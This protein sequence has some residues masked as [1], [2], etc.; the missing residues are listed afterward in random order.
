M[1]PIRAYITFFFVCITV[2]SS[3]AQ[4][5][6]LNEWM[7]KN[8]TV[9]AD[10]DGEFS[11]WIELY[12]SSSETINLAGFGITDDETNPYK[13]IFPSVEI[14]ANQ[15]LL[16]YCSGKDLVGPELHT[17]F[18][19]SGSDELVLT[20]E[21]GY[22]IST[23]DI[24]GVS[25]DISEGSVVDGTEGLT[26]FY[27]S[28]PGASNILGISNNSI[29]FS[30]ESGFY[31]SEFILTNS[32]SLGHEIR[33]TTDGSEPTL[34]DPIWGGSLLIEDKTDQPNSISLIPTNAPTLTGIYGWEEPI[35]SVRKG[36]VLRFRSFENGNPT[37]HITNRSYFVNPLGGNLYP[38]SVVSILTDSLNLFDYDSG[39]YVPGAAHDA[40]PE[41]G[42]TWGTGN[43]KESGEE[44]ERH[45]HFQLFNAEGDF[46][47]AQDIGIRIHGSGSTSLP[48]KSLRL[49]AREKYGE[50]EFDHR[51]FEEIETDKFEVLVLRNMGQDFVS[52]VAQDVL[53]NELAEDL[54]QASLQYRPTVVF[55]NGEYWGIQNLRERFDKHYLAQ[56]H[57]SPKD[58]IDV[59]E[60]YWGNIGMG[61]YHAFGDLYDFLETEDLS[62]ESNYTYVSGK[63]DIADFIDN[64]LARI[65]LGCYD[66]PGNNAKI[67]RE[68]SPEGQFRWLLL[69]NDVCIGSADFNSLVH[70]SDPNGPGWPNPPESTLFLRS[71]LENETFKI[72]F[73][74]RMAE[75]LNTVFDKDNVGVELTELHNHYS[76]VYP[77]HDNRWVV[78]DDGQ[79]LEENYSDVLDI[80]R[81]R[82]CYIREHFIDYF[83]LSEAEFGYDCD[84]SQVYLD[85]TLGEIDG[86]FTVYPNPSSGQFT[87]RSF[88]GNLNRFDQLTVQD[89]SGKVV[90]QKSIESSAGFTI[91]VTPNN[92]SAGLYIVRL[93]GE[94][95]DFTS[96]FFIQT[97]ETGF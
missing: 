78:L 84:S 82:P 4:G 71:L 20:D 8:S 35:T 69:D 92:L 14:N 10:Q 37:S 9:L 90:Y 46:E 15:F 45:A 89:L 44:W 64:T 5:V 17:N 86:G 24:S 25:F 93:K 54:N 65:Y 56:F 13:W 16:I 72:R 67:W 77:E 39:I 32:S 26:T 12:N 63:M 23:Y 97:E 83:N 36:V 18:K 66:W 52:G 94:A 31:T 43:Y 51:M 40:N 58:S 34:Q 81:L 95:A 50:E 7:V 11:D 21:D 79:T 47:F 61:T 3:L 87:I 57:E 1:K 28:T 62:I 80:I 96:K 48:Q 22:T 6:K 41:G 33:F 73:I 60:S 30:H 59:I 19:L 75:L 91:S 2:V 49:Y 42:G 88:N 68:R 27:G 70:A 74:D 38:L 76:P 53:A 85:V 29:S 55:I